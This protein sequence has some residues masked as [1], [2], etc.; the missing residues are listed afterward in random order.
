M[1]TLHSNMK[2]A[3]NAGFADPN[4]LVVNWKRSMGTD[5]VL[6]TADNSTTY[7]AKDILAILLKDAKGCIE[8]KTDQVVKE[9]AC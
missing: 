1:D 7:T 9:H 3:L 6:Y 4:R 2:N 8:S 5:T